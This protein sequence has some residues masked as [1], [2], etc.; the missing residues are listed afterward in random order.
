MSGSTSKDT[1]KKE[2]ALKASV[3]A[4]NSAILN[5]LSN[6]SSETKEKVGPIVRKI[7]ETLEK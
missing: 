2:L 5:E 7:A 4:K 6:V 3:A 1:S